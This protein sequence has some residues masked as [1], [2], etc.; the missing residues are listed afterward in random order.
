VAYIIYKKRVNQYHGDLVT[1]LERQETLP[2]ALEAY[3]K[4]LGSE[5]DEVVLAEELKPTAYIE[6]RL[7][8]SGAVV[9]LTTD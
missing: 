9:P 1:E 3:G 8:N 7:G 4:A 6:I 2:Q 5:W